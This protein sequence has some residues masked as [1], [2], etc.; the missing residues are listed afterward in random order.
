[1]KLIVLTDHKLR[2]HHF[3]FLNSRIRVAKKKLTLSLF[4]KNYQTFRIESLGGVQTFLLERG[5]K[6]EKGGG[7]IDVEMGG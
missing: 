3:S 6:P 5:D 2:R 4:V 1:M 7:G